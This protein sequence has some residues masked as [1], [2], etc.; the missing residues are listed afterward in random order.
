M[1]EMTI[2]SG[3]TKSTPRAVVHVGP[4][5]LVEQPFRVRGGEGRGH[6]VRAAVGGAVDA[7]VDP[8][9]P[10]EGPEDAVL[11]VVQAQTPADHF[12][13]RVLPRAAVGNDSLV[14]LLDRVDRVLREDDLERQGVVQVDPVRLLLGAREGQRVEGLQVVQVGRQFRGVV[15]VPGEARVVDQVDAAVPRDDAAVQQLLPGAVVD[16]FRALL[17]APVP[18]GQSDGFRRAAGEETGGGDQDGG[19]KRP[20]K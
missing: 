15:A 20:S 11:D 3:A 5:R 8:V 16:P 4:G 9:V 17:V 19:R 18:A 1:L 12:R 10:P 7:V 6:Q 2:R 14:D 13:V